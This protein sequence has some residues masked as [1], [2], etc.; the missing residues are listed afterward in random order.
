MKFVVENPAVNPDE[1]DRAVRDMVTNTHRDDF[2]DI[3]EWMIRTGLG[4][5]GARER[6]IR[7]LSERISREISQGLVQITVEKLEE[8]TVIKAKI[9]KDLPAFYPR[10]DFVVK[11]GAIDLK[12]LTYWFKVTS[13]VRLNDL[14]VE[15]KNKEITGI[16]SGTLQTSVTLAF[17]G[18]ER[19]NK[20]P[21]T[22]F[23]DKKI[24][25]LELAKVVKFGE[26]KAS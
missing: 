14:A 5:E 18:H 2:R 4:Q 12:T 3:S 26:P 22:L 17:C 24:I 23:K 25:E 16:R 15:L 1:I 19:E 7:E 20:S 8:E 13:L 21:F 10:I 11:S 6:L 9:E